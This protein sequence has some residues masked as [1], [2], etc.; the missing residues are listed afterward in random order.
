VSLTGIYEGGE[1]ERGEEILGGRVTNE[2]GEKKDKG[3]AE[4]IVLKRIFF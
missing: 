4:L 3:E 1:R 2:R